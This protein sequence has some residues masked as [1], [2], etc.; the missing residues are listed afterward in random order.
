MLKTYLV[1]GL[2]FQFEDGKQPAG[3][4]EVAKKGGRNH[5]TLMKE[6]DD[7]LTNDELKEAVKKGKASPAKPN[8]A[9]RKANK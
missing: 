7:V 6:A 4:K 9:A 3:A 2:T 5:A 8:K 1:N